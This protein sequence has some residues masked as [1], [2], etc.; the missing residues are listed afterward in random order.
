MADDGPPLGT[1][2]TTV[3]RLKGVVRFKGRTSFAEG[4]WIGVQTKRG[5][6][7]RGSG[8]PLVRRLVMGLDGGG[9]IAWL[10][11]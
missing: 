1:I 8:V 2:V 10:G 7:L 5:V 3:Q 9:E 11:A 6:V 4:K